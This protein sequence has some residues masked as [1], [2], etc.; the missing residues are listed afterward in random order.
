MSDSRLF[1]PGPHPEPVEDLWEAAARSLSDDLRS[2]IEPRADRRNVLEGALAEATQKQKQ[3]VE[4]RWKIKN[5]K[6]DVIILRD[7]FEKIITCINSFK[8]I[9]DSVANMGPG[10]AAIPWALVGVLLKVVVAD[11]ETFATMVEG[12]EKTTTIISRYS[13]FEVVYLKNNTAATSQLRSSLVPL[14]ASVL[15]FLGESHRYFA[16]TTTKRFMKAFVFDSGVEDLL[17][18]ISTK[19]AEV[20]RDS[21]LVATEVLQSTAHE[22]RSLSTHSTS[23][24]SQLTVLGTHLER[25]QQSQVVASDI[26]ALRDAITT[27]AHPVQRVVA[28]VPFYID[29]LD[30]TQRKIIL[31]WLSPITY[32]IQHVS[33]RHRRLPDSGAWMFSSDEFRA[34]KDSSISGTLWLHGMPGCGKTKLLFVLQVQ[35]MKTINWTIAA[36]QPCQI[37]CRRLR[38]QRNRKTPKFSASRL[39]LLLTQHS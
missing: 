36:N 11:N 31:D 38:T 3:C 2:A 27:M 1:V 28:T 15:T 39:F 22:I 7:V 21:L 26:H 16:R 29:G 6:G 37:C 9:G 14:Y 12:L 17:E 35:L 33:E 4:K 32:K 25:I 13:I 5:K 24:T 18:D 23:V 10:W 30:S 19:Q 8:G 20:D 34:W